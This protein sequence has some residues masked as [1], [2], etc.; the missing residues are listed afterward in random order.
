M[1]TPTFV[2]LR[3]HGEFSVVDGTVRIDDAV[4]AAADDRMPALALTDLANLFGLVKFYSAARNAGVKPI[5]GCDVWTTHASERDAPFRALLLAADRGGYLKLC[6]WLTRAYLGHQH[7]GRA[8]IDPA[9]FDEGTEGLIVL[10]GAR[11]SDVGQALLQGNAVVAKTAAEAWR[12]RFPGRC[13]R[14]SRAPSRTIPT[15]V[16]SRAPSSARR[17]PR[18]SRRAR[19]WST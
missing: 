6:D 16:S 4:R 19:S 3:L 13:P 5:A 11:A 2:H 7:R 14:S 12:R 15:S 17:S 9:W 1:S 8:E 18:T 10:A